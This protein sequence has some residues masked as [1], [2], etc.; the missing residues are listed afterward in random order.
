MVEE[1]NEIAIIFKRKKNENEF[2]LVEEFIPY[3]VVE[4]YYYDLDD[5]FI[6]SEGNIYS[7]IAST[8][9]VGNVFAGRRSIYETIKLNPNR[10]ISQIEKNVLNFAKSHEYYK[11]VDESS[12]EYSIVK[13]KNKETGKISRFEDK[14][15]PMYYEIYSTLIAATEVSKENIKKSEISSHSDNK[16]KQNSSKSTIKK[17][18]TPLELINEIKR[19]IKGQDEVIEAIATLI[20]MKYHYPDIPKSNILLIGPSGVGKTAIFEKIKKLLDIPIGMYGIPG[21]SQS[22]F[23]GHDLDEMLL[24]LYYESGENISTAE[25]GIIFIDEF[26]KLAQ[27]DGGGREVGTTAVQYELLKMLEGSN[28][29]INIDNHNTFSIDTSNILFVCCGAFTKLFNPNQEKV[30]GFNNYAKDKEKKKKITT[31]DIINYGIIKE[32]VGRLPV[33]IELN[34]LNNRP[35]ILRD[36]LLN[37]EDSLFSIMISVLNK[38]GIEIENL[39]E[40][41]DLIVENAM[42]KKIGA[43]GL[44]SPIRNMFLKIFYEINNNKGKYEKVILGKN[45][46]N[47]NRDFILIPKKVKRKV[48][49]D[50]SAI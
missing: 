16:D 44:I 30:I 27:D 24:N 45:I 12:A 10:S 8:A 28:S 41:I 11:N 19:S 33:I 1:I 7:H 14:D 5:L 49:T 40:V 42:N 15:T 37:S 17:Y 43:R 23:K 25:N 22:G 39:D 35:D 32:L 2:E 21:T 47:D 36:I 29:I 4:G 34:D 31:E 26:D 18:E 9:S 6:D 46:V 48:K 20:W 13:I 50:N 3:K 38:E